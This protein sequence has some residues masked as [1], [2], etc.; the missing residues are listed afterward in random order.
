M[1]RWRCGA[2]TRACRVE[3]LLD[4]FWPLWR[5]YEDK[6]RHECPRH[7]GMSS[8]LAP[9]NHFTQVIACEKELQGMRAAEHALERPVV[10]VLQLAIGV[11]GR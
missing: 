2:G 1:S 7:K 3:T 4:T 6:R 9:D 5:T 8:G 10:V 11:A